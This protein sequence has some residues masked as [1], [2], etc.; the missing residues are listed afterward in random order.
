[1]Y[2]KSS[3]KLKMRYL[4]FTALAG[5]SGVTH[6]AL[7]T[8]LFEDALQSPSDLSQWNTGSSGFIT[9]APDGSQGL[10]FNGSNAITTLNTFASSTGSFMLSF[11]LMGNC[12]HVS[13]CGALINASAKT[14]DYGWILAD[15]HYGSVL[16]IPD[17]TAG[18]WEH[19]TYTFSG[20]DTTLGLNV[21]Y[22]AP[23]LTKD[24]VFFQ[25][26]VLTDNS[27]GAAINTLSV[28]PLA[29]VTSLA[30]VPLPPSMLMFASGL[31]GFTAFR[32]KTA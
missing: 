15:T 24:S 18:T 21:Y 20:V 30:A 19:V 28:T 22:A 13:D 4:A 17:T 23:N 14:T 27:T 5:L 12:G 32:K 1:M 9:T 16:Q 6:T 11:D 26:I 2:I 31:L 3:L 10:T 8:T 29:A 25:N 7:A